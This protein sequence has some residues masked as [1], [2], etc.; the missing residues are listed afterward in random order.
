MTTF[1]RSFWEG[2]WSRVLREHADR[3]AHRPPNAHL[4]T[5]VMNLRPGLALDAGCGHGSDTLWLAERGWQ[6]TAVDFS[7]TAL[8]HARSTAEAVGA[9]VAER[10]DWVEGDLADLDPAAGPLRSRRLPLC[11]RAGIGGGDGAADGGRG[12]SRRDPVPGW[13]PPDR[14]G[15]WSRN[16]R[17]RSGAGLRRHR[18]RCARSPPLGVHRRRGPSA[19]HG[20]HRRRCCDLRAKTLLTSR[21]ESPVEWL[22]EF[23][24][25][26]ISRKDSFWKIVD[27]IEQP[28][29][30]RREQVLRSAAVCRFLSALSRLRTSMP[31]PSS[32]SGSA[33]SKSDVPGSPP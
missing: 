10:I 28:M 22:L 23:V 3:V 11:P 20:R 31:P 21:R 2:R 30:V 8:A 4:R 6:V 29:L 12:R 33:T 17:G 7:A 25:G 14:P 32:S 27:L 15:H 1:D 18:G 9:D 24:D 5:E 26:K 19:G 16:S 13:P